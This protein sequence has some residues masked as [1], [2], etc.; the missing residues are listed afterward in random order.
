MRRFYSYGPVDCKR[1]FCVPRHDSIEGCAQALIG[2]SEEGGHYFTI[3]APRQSG[4]T[5]IMRQVV[6]KIQAEYE[7]RFLVRTLSMQG[8][9]MK[10]DDPEDLFLSKVP[11]L[12]YDGFGIKNLP[13]PDSWE[14]L[15]LLFIKERE[16]PLFD[17]PLIL[18]IDEFDSLPQQVID[19]LVAV[20]RDLYLKQDRYLLHGL[21]LIGVRS[22]LGVESRRGS[23]FNIQRSLHIPNFSR[24][25]VADLFRQYQDEGGQQVEAE[26]VNKLY[27]MTNGQ[28]GLVGW[29]G[30]LLTENYNPGKERRIDMESWKHVWLEARVLEP[31]NT[32]MNLIAK[33]RVPEYQA[34]LLKLFTQSNIPFLFHD[35]LHNYLYL[36]GILDSEKVQ[37]SDGELTRV[38]RFSSPFVQHCLYDALSHELLQES[39]SVL[40]LEPLDTLEDV[41][42]AED[43]DLPA[44]LQ[45]YKNY[46]LRLKAKEINPWKEQPRRKADLHLTEA[47]GHFHLYAWL[48]DALG[49][50]CVVS[51]EFPTGN[52]KV[53]ISLKCGR[54]H[55]IIEVKSFRDAYQI[56][57]DREQASQYARELGFTSVTIALFIPI[58]DEK[59]LAEISGETLIGSI[60]VH[61]VAIG[62]GS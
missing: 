54:Q 16:T 31:N 36:H 53:D 56:G 35:P 6:K 43:F 12:F 14:S 41:F 2:T 32:V 8:V 13:V 28:P 18:F 50:R 15:E 9:V 10:D 46:L 38:C 30:E 11:Y 48:Q 59:I 24:E 40:A 44:L 25:E 29:F 42:Q 51:P 58:A 55:G 1:H 62:W 57:K 45:R 17:R 5:W 52:G 60:R 22:V 27:R 26:V 34:F 4:K 7:E 19:R 49:Q 37:R 33:A 47:V 20:F 21:A 39:G 61:V 23:P 3:W